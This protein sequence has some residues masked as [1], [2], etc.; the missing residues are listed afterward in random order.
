MKFKHLILNYDDT[1]FNNNTLFQISAAS[2][3]AMGIKPI[4]VDEN[5]QKASGYKGKLDLNINPSSTGATNDGFTATISL[6]NFDLNAANFD[7]KDTLNQI[8]AAVQI[9]NYG[10]NPGVSGC[11]LIWVGASSYYQAPPKPKYVPES[12]ITV[13]LALFALGALGLLKKTN[14]LHKS[15]QHC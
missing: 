12:R 13:A 3:Y 9:G 15:Q 11:D 2:P 6:K 1:K 7:F 10:D 4:T 5:N 14:S 8:Y